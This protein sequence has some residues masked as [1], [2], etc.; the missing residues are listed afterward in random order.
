MTKLADMNGETTTTPIVVPTHQTTAPFVNESTQQPPSN[1]SVPSNLTEDESSSVTT[2]LPEQST[3][4]AQN[5]TSKLRNMIDQASDDTSDTSRNAN[6]IMMTT[7]SKNKPQLHDHHFHHSITVITAVGLTLLVI[8]VVSVVIIGLYV[9]RHKN[10]SAHLTSSRTYV[11][12][13]Q[14]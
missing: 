14:N 5:E 13:Q 7:N 12:D 1:V 3:I 8:L 11:F 2:Q 6:T 9:N 10:L 4:K